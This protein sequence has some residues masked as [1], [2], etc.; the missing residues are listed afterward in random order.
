MNRAAT[1]FV[2]SSVLLLI[3]AS[4]GCGAG[5]KGASFG[6][7]GGPGTHGDA[8]TL[9]GTDG[10]TGTT[11]EGGAGAD[12]A[13]AM[14]DDCPGTLAA[15]TV[16]ALQ[17]GGP[18]DPAM[19]WLYPYDATVFA[20]GLLPPVLQWTPQAA[21]PASAVYLHMYSGSFDY[22]GCFGPTTPADLTP[23]AT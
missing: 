20:G 17:A 3:A 18:V 8:M 12:A 4:P 2:A 6:P 19:K 22:K 21:G 14:I 23:S 7:D 11:M 13:P 15:A 10:T 16:A 1:G 5:S 9:G